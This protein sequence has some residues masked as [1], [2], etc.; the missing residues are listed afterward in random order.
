MKA[1]WIILLLPLTSLAFN[2]GDTGEEPWRDMY[3]TNEWWHNGEHYCSTNPVYEDYHFMWTFHYNCRTCLDYY[4][5][6]E[7]NPNLTRRETPDNK[8]FRLLN[9]DGTNENIVGYNRIYVVGG[10]VGSSPPAP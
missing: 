5:L 3:I 7:H 8:Y 1:K 9:L 4:G 2:P 10:G 6:P